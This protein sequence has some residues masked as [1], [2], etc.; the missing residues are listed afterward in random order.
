M[1]C[2]SGRKLL[3]FFPD[4]K[5]TI[6]PL[7]GSFLYNRNQSKACQLFPVLPC[8]AVV[9]A[10]ILYKVHRRFVARVATK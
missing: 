6:H 2:F 5:K 1:Q 4:E 7:T 3:S 10:I 9:F 8:V